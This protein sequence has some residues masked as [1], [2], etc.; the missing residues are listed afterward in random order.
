MQVDSNPLKVEEA[1]YSK[2]LECMMMETTNGLIESLDV[3]SLAVSFEVLVVETIDGFN[4][5]AEDELN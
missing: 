5:R 4:K 3:V 1:L 2:P